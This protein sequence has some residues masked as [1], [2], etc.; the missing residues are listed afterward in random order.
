MSFVPEGGK[1]GRALRW[2]GSF[3]GQLEG[4]SGLRATWSGVGGPQRVVHLRY[5]YSRAMLPSKR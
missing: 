1:E 3:Q 4:A 5:L 2:R